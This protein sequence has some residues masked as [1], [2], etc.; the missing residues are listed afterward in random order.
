M[1]IDKLKAGALVL[2]T[3]AA[4]AIGAVG[5]QA[6]SFRMASLG[7]ASPTTVFSIAVSQIV[8][9]ENGYN[10]Q[11]TTGAVGTR[12]VVDAAN[13]QLDF[14]MTAVSINGYLR[15]GT[16]MYEKLPNAPELFGNVRSIVNYPLGAYHGITWADSGIE[17]MAD[18]KGKRVYVGPPS[19][20]GR[21][22]IEQVIR[23]VT[24]FEPNEDFETVNLD[25][26]SAEQAFQDRQLD[27]Y[28]VP[29]PIP[30]SELQQLSAIGEFRVLGIPDDKVDSEGIQAA[31]NVPG[32][33]FDYL[34]PQTYKGQVN[35][36]PV[37]MVSSI[38]GLGTHKWMDE[39]VVYN[40][41]KAIFE[42]HD[43]L[44][45]SAKWMEVITPEN[46]LMQMNAPLH[47]GAYR[48]YKEIGVDVPADLIPPEATQ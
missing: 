34:Q 30:S 33:N 23:G 38:V 9:K 43:D 31:F 10:M 41:T 25:W 48:Y 17:S 22:V 19:S 4:L 40:I 5:A 46:A 24:G 15:D 37:R 14:F 1:I 7:Q 6:Q 47:V 12:M 27:A 39:E 2:A 13:Q 36:E 32:R 11:L 18:L 20:A 35:Q 8:K 26:A 28:F 21:T 42:H 3:G 29:T 16:R 44:V 45:A